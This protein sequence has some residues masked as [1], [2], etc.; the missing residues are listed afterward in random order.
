MGKDPTNA[1]P[2]YSYNPQNITSSQYLLTDSQLPTDI[3]I[4]KIA[5]K[6]DA[7]TPAHRNR[8]P[9]KRIQSPYCTSFGSS[10]NGREKL[11]DMARL[12]FPFKECGI[13]DQVSPKLIGDYMN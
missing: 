12:H 9:S 7:D 5:V 4:T 6:T 10:E 2:L 3:P 1:R 13:T 11:K 8:M